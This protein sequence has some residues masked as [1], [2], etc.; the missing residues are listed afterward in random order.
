MK[1]I[2]RSSN[3]WLLIVA[4]IVIG[5]TANSFMVLDTIDD[6]AIIEEQIEN[7]DIIVDAVNQLHVAIL[8]VESGQRGFLLVEDQDFLAHYRKN[9]DLISAKINRVAEVASRDGRQQERLDNLVAVAREKLG[10]MITSVEIAKQGDLDSAVDIVETSKDLGLYDRIAAS[11]DEITKT[12]AETQRNHRLELNNL[13]GDARFNFLVSSV[14]VTLLIL[15]VF[16]IIYLSNRENLSHQKALELANEEL[17]SKVVSRTQAIQV[18]SDELSRSNRELEDFAFVASHDLQEPLRKIRAFGDRLSTGYADVIDDRG[19]DFL[20]RML[21]AAE[22]MSALISDLLEFSRVSTRG[23]PFTETSLDKVLKNILE[24]LEIAI[25]EKEAEI[26]CGE[27]P[28]IEGDPT[29]MGQLFLNL[30]S[31]ALKFQRE[32]VKPVVNIYANSVLPTEYADRELLEGVEYY[33]IYV[34]D[35][36]IGFEQEYEEKIFA[37]FQRLHGRSEYDGTGIG[38]AVCRRII[39]RHNLSL[40]HI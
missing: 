35:N 39:E 20:R 3:S 19:Q 4:L 17:E 10:E 21:N 28:T 32:S 23:K 40:I 5:I 12:E 30:V 1:Y 16:I 15:T 37:P 31:N 9:I 38:L 6:M 18:Y 7:T 22:R 27:L 26:N 13:I 33:D 36:G 25:E 14:V 8:T 34:E 29:Q 11:L 24:D 2:L